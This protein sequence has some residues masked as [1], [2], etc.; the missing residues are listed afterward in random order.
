[1]IIFDIKSFPDGLNTDVWLDFI[2]K[3]ILL[4]DSCNKGEKPVAAGLGI[5]KVALVDI[6]NMTD[7]DL[8]NI[9]KYIA[10]RNEEDKKKAD[11]MTKVI[12]QNN[13]KLIKYLRE[14]N[15]INK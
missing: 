8:F 12:S 10:D 5:E 14:I 1:M 15:D 11:L 2:S 3:G 7:E 13:E 4:Y 6:S 9:N